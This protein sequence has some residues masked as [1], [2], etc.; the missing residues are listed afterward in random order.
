MLLAVFLFWG[1]GGGW[2]NSN[3]EDYFLPFSGFTSRTSE[4]LLTSSSHFLTSRV[5]ALHTFRQDHFS[6]AL[7]SPGCGEST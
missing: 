5:A 6:N 4:S 3:E 1:G 2:T 7:K